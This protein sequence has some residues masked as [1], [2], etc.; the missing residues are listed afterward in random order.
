MACSRTPRPNDGRPTRA[1]PP[2]RYSS[3]R[4][5]SGRRALRECA[6][7]PTRGESKWAGG[8]HS[9]P[10]AFSAAVAFSG[11][12]SRVHCWQ[13]REPPGRVAAGLRRADPEPPT[14]GG[15]SAGARP[16]ATAATR[17]GAR[18]TRP[19]AI[20][21]TCAGATAATSAGA[22]AAGALGRLG[23]CVVDVPSAGRCS[24]WQLRHGR[25]SGCVGARAVAAVIKDSL[26]SGDVAISTRRART[27]ARGS[28]QAGRGA[29]R[30]RSRSEPKHPI[31]DEN[32]PP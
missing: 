11:A 5:R 20:V 8:D 4:E 19:G 32:S 9:V 21:A 18:G 13:A 14:A 6:H 15:S 3:T 17:P 10:S 26:A 1:P 23:C 30:K 27:S 31:S 29:S 25:H 7:S 24:R 22:T 2:P 28:V 16:G 12:L